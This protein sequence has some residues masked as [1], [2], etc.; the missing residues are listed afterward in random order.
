[1]TTRSS[2][3]AGSRVLQRRDR[4]VDAA[5]GLDDVGVL[6]LL[7]VERDRRPAVDA[8]E[9]GL[10]LLAVDDVGDLRQVDR[11]AALLRDDDPAEL[12]RILDLALDADDRVALAARDAARPGRPGSRRGSR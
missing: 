2:T 8:R 6:R 3:S 4:R 7:D 9:R 10:L 1:M 11:R 12:R 5:A